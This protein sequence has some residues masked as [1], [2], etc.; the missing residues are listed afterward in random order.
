LP[1]DGEDG[2]KD[3]GLLER[4][5]ELANDAIAV[6][7]LMGWDGEPCRCPACHCLRFRDMGDSTACSACR[8]GRHSRPPKQE[9]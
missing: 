6:E 5:G 4:L 3:R 8:A 1:D 2:D 9:E 7:T